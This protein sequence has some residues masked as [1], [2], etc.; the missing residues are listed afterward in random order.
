MEAVELPWCFAHEPEVGL[1]HEGCPFYDKGSNFPWLSCSIGSLFTS[2]NNGFCQV[3]FIFF[4]WEAPPITLQRWEYMYI[5]CWGK[6]SHNEIN[7]GSEHWYNRRAS[8]GAA[9]EEHNSRNR[10]H[11]TKSCFLLRWLKHDKQASLIIR[12]RINQSSSYTHRTCQLDRK[13]SKECIAAK[14]WGKRKYPKWQGDKKDIWSIQ[15]FPRRWAWR[16]KTITTEAA[17]KNSAVVALIVGTC[18]TK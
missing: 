17:N 7:G 15:C 9:P 4:F 16:W 3:Q 2:Q 14:W 11:K 5:N 1:F 6:T 12:P 18:G 10:H 8:K 13:W